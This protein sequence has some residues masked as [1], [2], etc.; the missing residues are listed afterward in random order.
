M[1]SLEGDNKYPMHRHGVAEYRVDDRYLRN[2]EG[3]ISVNLEQTTTIRE[4]IAFSVRRKFQ[5]LA[6]TIPDFGKARD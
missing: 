5:P 6:H 1:S 4:A 2:A 3:S